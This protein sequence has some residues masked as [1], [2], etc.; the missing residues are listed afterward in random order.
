MLADFRLSQYNGAELLEL[1]KSINPRL[2]SVLV[3]RQADEEAEIVGLESEIDLIIEYEKSELVNKAQLNRLATQCS[4][5]ATP[6]LEDSELVVNGISIELTRR[7]M[8]VVS[9]LIKNAG[10]VVGREEIAEMVWKSTKNARN[11][12]IHIKMIRIKLKRAGLPNFIITVY[13]EGY[14]WSNDES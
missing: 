11:I 9:I 14:C 10:E 3:I 4:K 1:S 2:Q 8:M 13:G 5:R 7:E 6:I 12:D